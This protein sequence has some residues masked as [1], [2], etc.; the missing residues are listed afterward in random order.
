MSDRNTLAY[1]YKMLSFLPW[2]YGNSIQSLGCPSLSLVL[3]APSIQQVQSLPGEFDLMDGKYT[4]VLFYYLVEGAG[5]D[6][7]F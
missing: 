6:I 5:S 3:P 7:Y 4:E 1:I 2:N